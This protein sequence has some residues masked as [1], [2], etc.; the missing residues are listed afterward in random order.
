[1]LIDTFITRIPCCC[2]NR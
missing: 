1:M 2:S